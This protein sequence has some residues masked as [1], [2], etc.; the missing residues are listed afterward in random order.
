[1][2]VER[3]GVLLAIMEVVVAVE[4]AVAVGAAVVVVQVQRLC[5]CSLACSSQLPCS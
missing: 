4:V 3:L 2:E 5:G 1:M